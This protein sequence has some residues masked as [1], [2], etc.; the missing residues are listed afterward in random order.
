M[1]ERIIQLIQSDDREMIDLGLDLLQKLPKS[2]WI[3]ILE[4]AFKDKKQLWTINKE[5]VHIHTMGKGIWEQLS[6]DYTRRTKIHTGAL[7][8]AMINKSMKDAFTGNTTTTK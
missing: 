7:G 4:T 1:E 8:I 5:G 3:E 6:G 2:Q